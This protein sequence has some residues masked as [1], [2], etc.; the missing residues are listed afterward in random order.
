[1]SVKQVVVETG[2]LVVPYSA[3]SLAPSFIEK[4]SCPGWLDCSDAAV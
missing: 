4:I 3:L 1:M 2:A